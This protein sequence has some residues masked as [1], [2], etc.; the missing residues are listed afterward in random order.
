ME[1]RN[2]Y[3]LRYHLRY[4]SLNRAQRNGGILKSYHK[5]MKS[6][7]PYISSLLQFGRPRI[8]LFIGESFPIKFSATDSK[9]QISEEVGGLQSSFCSSSDIPTPLRSKLDHK[10]SMS[11]I[12][13]SRKRAVSMG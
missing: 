1:L 12:G 9:G 5:P 7:F 13:R 2:W 10:S 8:G 11:S 3:H 6:Y 4:V